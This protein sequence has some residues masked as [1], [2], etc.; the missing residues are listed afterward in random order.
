MRKNVELLASFWTLSGKA[1]PHTDKEFC[2]FDFR[3]RV[4]A[5]AKA[6]F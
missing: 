1:E 4:E 2:R 6:G 5:A 3:D